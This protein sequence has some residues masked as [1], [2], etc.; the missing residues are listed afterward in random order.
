MQPPFLSPQ[1][2]FLWLPGYFWFSTMWSG[3][4]GMMSLKKNSS[5]PESIYPLTHIT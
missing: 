3:T 1:S 5:L 2:F 4:A